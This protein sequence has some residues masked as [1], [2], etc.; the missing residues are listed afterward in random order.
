MGSK[1]REFKKTIKFQNHKSDGAILNFAAHDPIDWP[2]II[3]VWKGL[4]VQKYIQN[5]YNIGNKIEDMITY[6]ETFLGESVKVL[7]EQWVES[8]PWLYE[9]LK[10][11]E[12]NPNNFTN[13]ISN[14]IIAEDPELGYTSLQNERLREIEKLTLTNWKGIKEF[15]QHY[16]YNATT[17]KQGYNKGIVERYFNKLPDPLGSMIFEE[18]KKETGGAVINISQA[19]TFVF[20]QLKKVCTNI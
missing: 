12:S 5:Q 2:N 17:A 4:V 16:L 8:N 19:I 14:I 1:R 13:I 10:R 3:S 20:K 9:E 11:V 7:W 18:Y 6:L 15:S